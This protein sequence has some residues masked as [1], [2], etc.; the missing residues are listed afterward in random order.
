MAGGRTRRKTPAVVGKAGFSF[1]SR[2]D[3]KSDPT[4]RHNL[5]RSS[6]PMAVYV[7]CNRRRV[8]GRLL[9]D[10]ERAVGIGEPSHLLAKHHHI[11]IRLT[12][13]RKNVDAVCLK[14]EDCT[15]RFAQAGKQSKLDS[16]TPMHRPFRSL[17]RDEQQLIV[18]AT[19]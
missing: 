3:S 6:N 15:Q 9:G 17:I 4:G 8:P 14:T 10:A 16:G 11:F 13:N 18:R 5:P 19:R 7:V 2:R 1:T 12:A